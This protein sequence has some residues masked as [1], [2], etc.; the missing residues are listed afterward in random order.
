MITLCDLTQDELL[1]WAPDPHIQQ[2]V[3]CL[4]VDIKQASQT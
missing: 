3:S 1:L 2:A 4:S